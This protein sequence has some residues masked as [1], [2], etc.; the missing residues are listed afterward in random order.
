MSRCDERDQAAAGN[1]APSESCS[2]DSVRRA[3][4]NPESFR[5]LKNEFFYTWFIHEE[6]CTNSDMING[7]NCCY[8][9]E[10]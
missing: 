10:C 8:G 9:K 6:F 3:A 1:F 5:S 7:A 4:G 2:V